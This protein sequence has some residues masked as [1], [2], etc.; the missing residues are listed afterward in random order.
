MIK[1]NLTEK[2][3]SF[4][5]PI[6]LG[7]DFTNFP[8]KLVLLTFILTQAP[9][10]YFESYLESSKSDLKDEIS[11]MR[12]TEKKMRRDI[13]KNK[14]IAKELAGYNKKIEDLKN[15]S[16]QVEKILKIRTNP[17]HLLERVARFTPKDLW[18]EVLKI[19]NG[20]KISFTGGSDSYRSI[21]NFIKELNETSY[22]D[23]SLQLKESKTTVE[24][25]GKKQYQV[26]SFDIKG[27]INTFNPFLEEDS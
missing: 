1:I 7:F 5:A 22:F 14:K 25:A 13:R 20:K 8:V 24:K 27:K 19:T 9:L 6:V 16:K 15:R 17:R 11:R 26:E 12:S 18:L 21:G 4:K 2:K 10:Y 3:K 23:K